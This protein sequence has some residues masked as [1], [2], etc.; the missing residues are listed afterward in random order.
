MARAKIMVATCPE[1]G[2][3]LYCLEGELGRTEWAE[4]DRF[5][6]F[7][8]NLVSYTHR[9]VLLDSA[10]SYGWDDRAPYGRGAVALGL[11]MAYEV[12]MRDLR[13]LLDYHWQH[14]RFDAYRV[15][16]AELVNRDPQ[17]ARS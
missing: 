16:L 6:R 2:R 1:T 14:W 13:E 5:E 3:D 7:L 17:G 4:D 10:T 12:R 15:E 8:L 9:V 11:D